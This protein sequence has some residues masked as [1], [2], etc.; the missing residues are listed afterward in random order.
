MQLIWFELGALTLLVLLLIWRCRKY[1]ERCARKAK[2][3]PPGHG[4]QTTL[5]QERLNQLRQDYGSF[6]ASRPRRSPTHDLIVEAVRR[7]LVKLSYFR[8]ARVNLAANSETKSQ[9]HEA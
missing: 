8:S 7:S 5:V 6:A 4:F 9:A 1:A 3:L 2:Y